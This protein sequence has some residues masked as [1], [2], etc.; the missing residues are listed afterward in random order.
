MGRVESRG[1][2]DE[3]GREGDKGGGGGNGDGL[4]ELE[5]GSVV[6]YGLRSGILS[7]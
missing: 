7:A 3:V 6:P 4:I 1:W 2:Y 5:E